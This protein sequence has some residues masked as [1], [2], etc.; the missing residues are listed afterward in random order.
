MDYAWGWFQHSASQRLTTFNFFLVI[1]GLLLVAYGQAVEHG[2]RLFGTCLGLVG[3]VVS[4]GF[5]AIDVRNEVFVNRGIDAL[6]ELEKSIGVKVGKRGEPSAGLNEALGKGLIAS[7]AVGWIDK[8]ADKDKRKRR[9]NVFKYR[10]WF[11]R[12]IILV[13]GA[14]G[15]GLLWAILGFPTTG[16]PSDEACRSSTVLV[17]HRPG[18]DLSLVQRSERE[19]EQRG[20]NDDRGRP[21]DS[22]SGDLH[23]QSIGMGN[24]KRVQTGRHCGEEPVGGG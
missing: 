20:G 10:F 8:P 14:F 16:Q 9:A 22:L 18:Y 4:I 3:A 13:G 15:A 2:W 7:L 1:V 12:V 21:N 19:G 5:L 23:V 17:L 11:R 24:N 6:E